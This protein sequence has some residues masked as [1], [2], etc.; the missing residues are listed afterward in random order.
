MF[1]TA[2]DPMNPYND[3]QDENQSAISQQYYKGKMP[4]REQK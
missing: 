3:V 4:W 1:D 2:F